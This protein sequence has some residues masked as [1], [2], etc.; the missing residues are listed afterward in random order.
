MKEV[1]VGV[2]GCGGIARHAHV[3]ALRAISEVKIVALCDIREEK[4]KSLKEEQGL[5]DCK[6]YTDYRALLQDRSI[7]AVH[8]CTP[9]YLH[10]EMAVAALQAGKHVFCEKPDAVSPESAVQMAQAERESGKILMCMRNNRHLAV[11]K[12]LK[13]WIEEGK[14]GEIYMGRCGW[15]R[16]R[17]IPGKGGWFTTK[18]LSGG[19]ALIDLGVHMIDLAIYFMGN[20][21]PIAVSGYTC[22]KFAD[23][24][25]RSDSE[26]SKFGE[27][28]AD[29]V[30]D[31]EDFA[32]GMIRFED[33]TCL[34]IEFSWASNIEREKNFVELRG[35]KSGILWENGHGKIFG[36]EYGELF[37]MDL[38]IPETN[39]HAANIRHFYEVLAGEAQADYRIEQGIDIIRILA[40]AYRSAETGKE[41]IL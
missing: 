40:A 5:C 8:I 15:I 31:V 38:R 19:G 35:S 16:R 4:A 7:D 37:D 20:R 1:R 33:G 18:E 3:P 9:N 30:F 36:E 25:V 39:G 24:S 2:I 34:Q 27:A 17:G 32:A 12:F 6:I 29:A 26:H 11:T 23:N 13:K 14:A 10:A 22:R 28:K 41:V 21:K